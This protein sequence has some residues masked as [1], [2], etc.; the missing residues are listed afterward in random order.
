VPT[1][2]DEILTD[3]M[4]DALKGGAIVGF[5]ILLDGVM[6]TLSQPPTNQPITPQN[7]GKIKERVTFLLDGKTFVII[8]HGPNMGK[9]KLGP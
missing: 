3:A 7:R 4:K 8:D 5:G 6:Q 2:T 1:I 9:I